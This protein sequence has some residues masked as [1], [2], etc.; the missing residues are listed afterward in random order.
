MSERGS[1]EEQVLCC[2]L[3]PCSSFS[4]AFV[5]A[6]PSRR[7][8]WRWWL[9]LFALYKVPENLL[10]VHVHHVHATEA[11]RD[12]R[13]PDHQQPAAADLDLQSADADADVHGL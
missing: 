12:R 13:P 4:R 5:L 9:V 6:A 2:V 11:E 3:I 10:H 8:R 1:F 7:R